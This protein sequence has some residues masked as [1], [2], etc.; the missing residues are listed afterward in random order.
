M[1]ITISYVYVY[2]DWWAGSQVSMDQDPDQ[3]FYSDCGKLFHNLV[4]GVVPTALTYANTAN[5]MCQ[6]IIL[7][8]MAYWTCI[9]NF[10][11]LGFY[12]AQ[13]TNAETEVE[14]VP[15]L[16]AEPEAEIEATEEP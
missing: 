11:N 3:F 9:F 13:E 15:Q 2:G 16:E 4:T 7:K 5:K 14:T 1:M 6:A 10:K 8:D 12:Q